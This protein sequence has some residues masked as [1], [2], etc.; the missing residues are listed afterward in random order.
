MLKFQW[1]Q[2]LKQAQD[3][4]QPLNSKNCVRTAKKQKIVEYLFFE[5]AIIV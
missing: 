1:I 3:E 4:F 2:V 5:H